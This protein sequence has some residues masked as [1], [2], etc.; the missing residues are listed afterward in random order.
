MTTTA[1]TVAVAMTAATA[2]TAARAT[3][4][5]VAAAAADNSPFVTREPAARSMNAGG[6]RGLGDVRAHVGRRP[7]FAATDRGRGVPRALRCSDIGHG[8]HRM[9]PRPLR[10]R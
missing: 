8:S 2:V 3:T 1:A 7:D 10:V 6:A 5:T 4:T 9:A